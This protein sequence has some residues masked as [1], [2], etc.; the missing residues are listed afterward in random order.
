M[1]PDVAQGHAGVVPLAL[2]LEGANPGEAPCL[3]RAPRGR[4]AGPVLGAASRASAPASSKISP[5][6]QLG[7]R[8]P[9]SLSSS[10][11]CL[12]GWGCLDMDMLRLGQ[13]VCKRKIV[14]TM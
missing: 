12:L 9:G 11:A 2:S 6:P 14:T 8:L 3:A 13:H 1:G 4:I 10:A 5:A 7:V